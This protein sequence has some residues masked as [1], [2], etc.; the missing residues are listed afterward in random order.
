MNSPLLAVTGGSTVF[1]VLVSAT[2]LDSLDNGFSESFL[3]I[4]KNKNQEE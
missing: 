2:I 1:V 4:K 3:G